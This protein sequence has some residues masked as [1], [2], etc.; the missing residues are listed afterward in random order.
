M[1]TSPSPVPVAVLD[2]QGVLRLQHG[3][4]WIHGEHLASVTAGD[5]GVLRLEGPAGVAR[6]AAVYG[7]ASRLPL[8]VISRDPAFDVRDP[9]WWR[10]RLAAALARRGWDLRRKS[11]PCNRSRDRPDLEIEIRRSRTPA[12]VVDG[13]PAPA[14]PLPDD[15]ACRLVHAEADGLPGLVLDAYMDIAV[16]QAGCRWADRVA[17]ELARELVERHGFAGVLA[18]NDGA[19]RRPEGLEESV[20]LLAGDVPAELTLILG[21]ALRTIDPWHG[22]KTGAYLDQRDNQAWA[23]AVL[24]RGRC[25]DAFANEGGFALALARRNLPAT[26]LSRC[27]RVI[28]RRNSPDEVLPGPVEGAEGYPYDDEPR[29]PATPVLALDSSAPAL[30]RLAANAARNGVAEFIETRR[31]NVFD[32]LRELPAGSFDGVVL[33][34]PALAKRKGDLDQALR[35]YRDLNLRALRLLRPGGRLITCSCSH[36]LSRDEFRRVLGQAAAAAGRDAILLAE[37]GASDCHPRLLT[38]PESDYL[39]VLLVEA[40]D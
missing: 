10:R 14:P 26:A 15:E 39:K 4:P 38:F 6:G 3:H 27:S 32:A 37:R 20:V 23:A 24:P 8:R 34:P 9:D 35:A 21:G 2:R 25:L 28:L 29:R 19:F 7:A 11:W 1:S 30:A 12:L 5:G 40:R 17:P 31:A 16:L 36:H 18:R 22:Q 33:D 13:P